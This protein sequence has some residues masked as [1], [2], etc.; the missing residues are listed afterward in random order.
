MDLL[1]L[2]TEIAEENG[3]DTWKQLIECFS[4]T[5]P[6]RRVINRE[7]TK[8]VERAVANADTGDRQLTIPDVIKCSTCQF[9]NYHKYSIPCSKCCDYSRYKE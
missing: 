6:G 1:K 8:L 2:K 4:T 7:V 5:E 3:F 9:K